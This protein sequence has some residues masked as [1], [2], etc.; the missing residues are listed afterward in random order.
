MSV[1]LVF[2]VSAQT[3]DLK[4]VGSLSEV[5]IVRHEENNFPDH[6]VDFV[7]HISHF[8][9]G[10][11]PSEAVLTNIETDFLYFISGEISTLQN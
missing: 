2:L 4:T 10:E 6:N 7:G 3:H 11:S 8:M 5:R 9:T 1:H